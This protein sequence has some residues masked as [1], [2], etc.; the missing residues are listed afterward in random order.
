VRVIV[1]TGCFL[2]AA[3]AWYLLVGKGEPYSTYLREYR[4][5]DPVRDASASWEAGN[6]RL[7]GVHGV[8][9]SAPGVPCE[10]YYVKRYGIEGIRGTSDCITCSEQAEFQHVASE[11]ARRYNAEILR[12]INITP[13]PKAEVAVALLRAQNAECALVGGEVASVFL[14]L[15]ALKD[16]PTRQAAR[17][18]GDIEHLRINA[19]IPAKDDDLDRLLELPNVTSLD[20]SDTA[21]TDAGLD[22][23]A[24]LPRL[25]F[26]QLNRTSITDAGLAKL[27]SLSRLKSLYLPGTSVGDAGMEAIQGLQSLELL[28]LTG[29]RVTDAGLVPIGKLDNLTDLMLSEATTDSGLRSLSGLKRLRCLG[30]QFSKVTPAGIA[31]LKKSVPSLVIP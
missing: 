29:T 22:R 4:A 2:M 1:A 21:I 27:A 6:H 31:A 23:V 30:T 7:K 15:R 24:R 11:Y 17:N 28:Y 16:P 10:W 19:D 8:G 5:K 20:L 18:L 13:S 12:R 9:L 14:T 26:L 3:L 25:E